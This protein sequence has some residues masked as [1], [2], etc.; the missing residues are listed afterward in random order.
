[1]SRRSTTSGA[2][3]AGTFSFTYWDLMSH[4]V[5]GILVLG[6]MAL[7]GALF[8]MQWPF[9]T[10][11]FAGI[12]LGIA[13]AYTIGHVLQALGSMMGRFYYSTWGG[14]PAYRVFVGRV[15]RDFS[16][17]RFEETTALR[18]YM[19]V[20]YAPE[21]MSRRDRVVTDKANAEKMSTWRS[22]QPGLNRP[23]NTAAART[24]GVT[25]QNAP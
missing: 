1:M 24:A 20:E 22:D 13:V 11:T 2:E 7:L 4:L 25:S 6:A 17:D 16:Y 8:E 14:K 10:T 3:V 23:S 18:Q 5:P 9:G 15:P 19:G 12:A 21:T